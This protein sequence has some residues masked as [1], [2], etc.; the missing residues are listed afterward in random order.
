MDF[1]TLLR[2]LERG[3][4]PP[5][6]LL[7]GPE[8]FLLEDA[9]TRVTRALF[10]DPSA[11][12][13]NRELLDGGETSV[14]TVVRAAL[15]LP[16]VA[17][18]RLVVVK[19]AQ[20][21][22]VRES[23]PLAEY[24]S[25]PNAS[26][27]LLLLAD[28]PL[29]AHGRGRKTDHWLL[30][31]VPSGAVVPVRRLSGPPLVAWLQKR[32]AAEG[33]QISEEAAQL[34]VEWVGDDLGAL[35]GDLEKAA[36][37]GSAADLRVGVAEVTAVVGE[38]RLRSVFDLTRALERR[39]LG[40]ALTVLDRVL[41]AG[42]E[43]LAVLGMVTRELRLTWLAR[44]WARQGQS[45]EQLTRVLRRPPHAVES[46]LARANA[47]SSEGFLRALGRCWETERRLKSGGLARPE[48][49]TLLAELCAA[50]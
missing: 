33:I 21:L 26:T 6:L 44:E 30:G 20:E 36:L 31:A 14:D 50:G 9:L 11:V 27:C 28:E 32:A 18:S 46:L 13:L 24:A 29:R 40:Q 2:E 45:T 8:P 15:T 35:V 17:P 41:A 38:Q 3:R 1:S 47:F 7:H 5:L 48:I 22:P 12:A 37:Y 23:E 19:R 39:E 16:C 42:E 4:V 34:L 25:A 43:P 49:A 10:P